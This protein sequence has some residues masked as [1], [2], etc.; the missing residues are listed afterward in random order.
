MRSQPFAI[1]SN[2]SIT[3]SIARSVTVKGYCD[4]VEARQRDAQLTDEAALCCPRVDGLH[5]TAGGT[6]KG[7]MGTQDVCPGQAAEISPHSK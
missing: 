4:F 7:T 5:E 6:T 3:S 1:P 2:R